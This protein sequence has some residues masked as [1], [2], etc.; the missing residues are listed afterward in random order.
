MFVNTLWYGF[1]N[2]QIHTIAEKSQASTLSDI[3]V[4]LLSI[5]KRDLCVCSLKGNKHVKDP[6][7]PD[8]KWQKQ[9]DVTEVT[10]DGLIIDYE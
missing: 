3:R 7:F 8:W 2:A 1:I 9:D 5:L 6:S 10:S 4:W